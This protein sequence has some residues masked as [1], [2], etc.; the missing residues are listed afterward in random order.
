CC[1]QQNWPV[2][3]YLDPDHPL[4]LEI[5]RWIEKLSGAESVCRGTDGCSAPVFYLRLCQMALLFAHLAAGKEPLLFRSFQIMRA[6]PYMIGGEKRFDTDLMTHTSLVCKVGGEA[7][8]CVGV[9][10]GILGKAVGVA[11]KIADGN[12]RALY[13]VVTALLRRMGA[14]RDDQIE[15]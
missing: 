4:Q 11:V 3:N 14:I 13:P 12:S 7:V 15:K 9:P 5:L 10:P 6:Q 8:E 1:V 2:E